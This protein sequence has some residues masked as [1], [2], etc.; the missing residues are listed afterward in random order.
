MP[1]PTPRSAR[2]AARLRSR[3]L[4]AGLT[5]AALVAAAGT[6]LAAPATAHA[7]TASDPAAPATA[8]G[9][10]PV[11][12]PRPAGSLVDAYGVNVHISGPTGPYGDTGR[13]LSALTGL[14]VRHVRNTLYGNITQQWSSLR[15]LY[16]NGI[17]SDLVMGDPR[18]P[19][20]P[21]GL[22]QVIK[23]QF[24]TGLI[25]SVEGANEWNLSGDPAWVA[26]DRAYQ[27]KIW[28]AVK[29]DPA[30][31]GIPVLAPALGMRSGFSD[32]GD[33][34]AYSDEG[35][36]HLYSGAFAP[37]VALD[38]QVANA[39][40]VVPGKPVV[41]TE[42]GYHNAMN[43]KAGHV[44]TPEGVVGVYAPRV[45]LDH[46]VRGTARVYDYELLDEKAEPTL[47]DPE[48]HFGLLR[49]DWTPKPAY[50]ALQTLLHAAADPGPDTPLQPLDYQVSGATPDV[51]QVLLQKHDGSY[52]LAL[53]RDVS[54][55]DRVAKV[56]APPAP[57]VVT[58]GLG[59]RS[60]VTVDDVSDAAGPTGPDQPVD[61]V[62]VPLAGD[63]ELVRIAPAAAPDTDLPDAPTALSARPADGAAVVS[64]A[65]AGTGGQV[66]GYTVT[67]TP[68]DGSAPISVSAS[69]GARTVLVPGLT[70]DQAYA[71]SVVA[72]GPAGT[73]AP[74]VLDAPVVPD[75]PAGA[76]AKVTGATRDSAVQVT[77][78]APAAGGPV[79]SYTVTANHG[80]GS[81]TV[82]APASAVLFPGLLNG[83][84]Y[85]FSVTANGPGGSGPA[86]PLSLAVRPTPLP[87]AVASLTAAPGLRSATAA[88]TAPLAGGS[89]SS[90][91]IT[92]DPVTFTRSA[93]AATRTL[94][95]SGLRTGVSYRVTVRANGASGQ[96]LAV[97]SGPVTAG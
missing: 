93:S 83:T 55:Y 68:A 59:V 49:S 16:A 5:A 30:T 2:R 37:D 69:A 1:A 51:H 36:V 80:G 4:S 56:P 28:N 11:L 23:A 33:L 76:I 53:W 85:A 66:S 44:P 39:H 41:F 43:T 84:A 31:A 24:P 38:D 79:T 14:G 88:W 27:A 46:Y 92:T 91:S 21:A 73:A 89:V 60:T 47:L 82:P 34:S 10:L 67:A 26:T 22:V 87:G 25:D 15:T 58:V 13:V 95:L 70:D 94:V 52:L 62:S 61:Q 74:A 8:P 97:T 18:Q 48:Q 81:L 45:L 77:W 86:S 35:N 71:V 78:T 65:A 57:V 29:G 3:S 9:V 6:A 40:L 50:T 96:G 7:A 17:R 12:S 75:A 90:Y 54:V 20:D 63:V 72:T 42:T 64:W 32:L 19:T